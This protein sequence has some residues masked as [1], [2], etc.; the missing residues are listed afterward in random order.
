MSGPTLSVIVSTRNRRSSVERLVGLLAKQ[1]LDLAG[2]EA[3]IV[4]DGS[5]DDTAAAARTWQV[6]FRLHVTEQ[7]GVGTAGARN[8]GARAAAGAIL[9]FLAD[10]LVPSPGLLEAHIAAHD[11][12]DEGVVVGWYPPAREREAG[13][14]AMGLRAWWHDRFEAMQEPSH[15]FSFR[16]CLGGNVSVPATLFR[17]LG[18]FDPSFTETRED[19]ELGARALMAGASIRFASAATAEWVRP[20]WRL[21]DAFERARTEG[22]ADARLGQAHPSLRPAMPIAAFGAPRTRAAQVAHRLAFSWPSLGNVGLDVLTMLM[23]LT[24]RLQL[25]SQWHRLFAVA[26]RHCYL[27]GVTEVIPRR[28]AL[29]QFLQD[30]ELAARSVV[31]RDLEIDLDGGVRDGMNEVDRVRPTA[32]RIRLRGTP[33]GVVT[34][35]PGTEALRGVHVQAALVRELE[36][37]MFLAL[38]A[39]SVIG[40]GVDASPGDL[41]VR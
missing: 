38:V 31:P 39:G 41:S 12:S 8:A 35:A 7:P 9:L 23:N 11:E 2:F 28:E 20:G 32:V 15:R 36:W 18:G 19:H 21:A 6:P 4:V 17:Q 25:R 16:D 24:E 30:G 13:Y 1:S 27:R 10:D 40:V 26:E 29:Y 14:L 5:A 33:I 37:P 3:I 22:R 34:S